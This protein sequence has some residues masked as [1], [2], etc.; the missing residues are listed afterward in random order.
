MNARG[1]RNSY[2]NIR[3][4]GAAAECMFELSVRHEVAWMGMGGE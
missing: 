4:S 3:A 2:M 1:D